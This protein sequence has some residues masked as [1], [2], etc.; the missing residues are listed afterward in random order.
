MPPI[1]R[2]THVGSDALALGKDLYR[3]RRQP[4]FDRMLIAAE[5]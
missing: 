4:H 5:K 3:P 1:A 2:T